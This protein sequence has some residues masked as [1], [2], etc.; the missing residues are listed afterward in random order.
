M[1]ILRSSITCD[2]DFEKKGLQTSFIRLTY[3]DNAHAYGIIPIPIAVIANGE[4]PTVFLA[5]G[6]HGD[7]YEG[8]VILRQMINSLDPA[9]VSGRLIIMPALNYPAVLA[10][11]RI[12]PLDNG[13]L[14]RVFPGQEGASP[15]LAIAHF[16]DNRILPLCDALMDLH[17]GGKAADMIP[18]T[19][20]CRGSDA[21][22]NTRRLELLEAFA[23]PLIVIAGGEA[24]PG[25]L[26]YSAAERHSIMSFSTELGGG[27]GVDLYGLKVGTDGVNRVLSKL[28]VI[29][30]NPRDSNIKNSRLVT[31]TSGPIA[32]VSGL[33]EPYCILGEEVTAGQIVGCIHPRDN[34]ERKPSQPSFPT[35]G[36]IVGRRVPAVVKKGDYLFS[37]ANEVTREKILLP[38]SK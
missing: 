5:A 31:Y 19:Y 27:G 30:P 10:D 38:H 18:Q 1:N 32:P 20:L 35:G 15:T 4:G 16:V 13:N 14:A 3:S 26:D 9:S 36:I 34:P 22:L 12:S 24:S 17:S 25:Y 11:S 29:P 23:A 37:L 28:G 6:T 33:F 2:I 7:E 21:D 8:Q